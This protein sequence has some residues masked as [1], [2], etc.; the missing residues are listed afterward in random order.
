MQPILSIC[1]DLS[2]YG[3]AWEGNIVETGI[4]TIPTT[5]RKAYIDCSGST[6]YSVTGGYVG[7]GSS[8]QSILD[9][10]KT[11][12]TDI[13][14]NIF[15]VPEIAYWD[16][17]SVPMIYNLN[18]S[19]TS[20][21]GMS[22]RGGTQPQ[23]IAN[24]P[25]FRNVTDG[26]LS[27][28]TDGGIPPNDVPKFDQVLPSIK[29]AICIYTGDRNNPPSKLNLPVFAPLIKK[30]TVCV[31]LH[32]DGETYKLILVNNPNAIAGS[33]KEIIYEIPN[34]QDLN[35][36][37]SWDAFPTVSPDILKDIT[38]INV[39]Y[40]PTTEILH[41]GQTIIDKESLRAY[42]LNEEM[43]LVSRVD[44]VE[45]LLETVD[46]SILSDTLNFDTEMHF[47]TTL[48]KKW[49]TENRDRVNRESAERNESL[50]LEITRLE[51][52]F[53]VNMESEDE[54]VRKRNTTIAPRL[55]ELY[56][57]RRKYS[58]EFMQRY[59][60]SHDTLI[61]SLSK[62][63]EDVV[64]ITPNDYSLRSLSAT[65]APRGNRMKRAT[66]AEEVDKKDWDL[67][68][69]Y[70]I[71]EGSHC[72]ICYEHGG[73][74]TILFVD[75]F[76]EQTEKNCTNQS[77]NN[78]YPLGDANTA[79]LPPGMLCIDC[80]GVMEEMGNPH[81]TTRG[82]IGGLLVLGD[83]S[84]NWQVLM[85][86]ATKCFYGG[87]KS[88]VTADMLLSVLVNLKMKE[89]FS[90]ESLNF[91]ISKCIDVMTANFE[92]I[93]GSSQPFKEA[94]SNLLVGR[95]QQMPNINNFLTII[96][97]RDPVT[98]SI[99]THLY[100][101]YVNEEVN[102][103]TE[104]ILRNNIQRAFIYN[105][106]GQYLSR[107]K[108]DN[109]NGK[110]NAYL[111]S[112][113]Y[114]MTTG[115]PINKS[116]K[117]TSYETS[118]FLKSC[119]GEEN[120]VKMNS[121]VE[122]MTG[123]KMTY[124][125]SPP[126]L[127]ALYLNLI[128][129]KNFATKTEQC[130]M[131]L[132]TEMENSVFFNALFNNPGGMDERFVN[133]YLRKFHKDKILK[134]LS[135]ETDAHMR[136]PCFSTASSQKQLYGLSTSFCGSCGE[137]FFTA[138]D[139]QELND[140][141]TLSPSTITRIRLARAEHFKNVYH[142]DDTGGM[143]KDGSVNYNLHSIVYSVFLSHYKASVDAEKKAE[144]ASVREEEETRRMEDA[145]DEDYDEDDE[146]S[147]TE[148]AV[149]LI[150]TIKEKEMRR[151]AE[152][153]DLLV[154]P[155]RKVILEILRKIMKNGKGNIYEEYLLFDIMLCVV[156]LSSLVK[157][158]YTFS[159]KTLELD[160]KIKIELNAIREGRLTE[161]Q[162]SNYYVSPD[163]V[164]EELLALANPLE[165]EELDIVYSKNL[166]Q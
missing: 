152:E 27:F 50:S 40:D 3:I 10:E 110:T 131:D 82:E 159:E 109:H 13:A 85:N 84:R 154:N 128:K 105:V 43:S 52:E 134:R 16:S 68:G 164:P 135:R 9:A 33:L 157:D 20:Y 23:T 66:K 11:S 30:A 145:Y 95:V 57:E 76:K 108:T 91:M 72:S 7:Y 24:D 120:L 107:C 124:L 112:E 89:R 69:A 47:Y 17:T 96:R 32:W 133:T 48:V 148:E 165:K 97:G 65:V 122:W 129:I 142:T 78:P 137:R 118:D 1:P 29:F 155:T 42:L 121:S 141:G 15:K 49:F 117:M 51:Q 115:L 156:N 99:L 166:P 39:A 18:A 86:T 111:M 126:I 114:E 64:E 146:Y 6:N 25:T 103:E 70:R 38:A 58:S 28:W 34:A 60:R 53:R 14:I 139:I 119:F 67:E 63:E 71:P 147:I 54:E 21:M 8:A 138:Q 4:N 160:T 2:T 113:L 62:P 150:T 80:A 31:M 102:G 56:N 93:S 143:P 87:T 45:Y 106:F 81:H 19:R 74:G 144:E 79:F 125:I 46:Y 61:E 35:E 161:E 90:D 98:I 127:T 37:V 130:M 163:A 5:K 140:T 123:Y 75:D 59:Q 101:N 162:I 153:A 12:A 100:K 136:V 104:I 83:P 88:P 94:L 26:V 149:D 41:G 22:A 116:E 73:V 55:R 44:C 158:G 132:F 77:L 36:D 92:G 151:A